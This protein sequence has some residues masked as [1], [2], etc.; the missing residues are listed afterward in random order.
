MSFS[1]NKSDVVAD[2]Y[3]DRYRTFELWSGKRHGGYHFG[4]PNKFLD[5]FNY[6]K[7]VENLSNLVVE[8]LGITSET[9]TILDAGCGA[10]DIARRIKK[11]HGDDKLKVFGVTLSQKQ[12]DIGLERLKKENVHGVKLLR[13]DFNR[14]TFPDNY[15]D[16]VFYVDSLCYGEGHGKVKEMQEC[17]RVLKPGGK[18]LVS[19]I[20]L[21]VD[22]GS[23]SQRW[24]NS[25]ML[26][27]KAWGVP[28]WI[29]EKDFLDQCSKI[30]LEKSDEM[31][32]TKKINLS[33][34]LLIAAALVLVALGPVLRVFRILKKEE[35]TMLKLVATSLIKSY[36]NN[37][38]PYKLIT[39]KKVK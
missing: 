25:D 22:P 5:N 36:D 38:A 21:S 2:I 17:F 1:E 19:D 26:I 37:T 34:K 20:F 10:G 27:R 32:L 16:I 12:I 15:F 29:V 7:M 35:L 14:M 39:L 9:R 3:D 24:Q 28:G 8:K 30:G 31:D 13:E 18:L 33:M 23:W 6:S 11:Q 4:F